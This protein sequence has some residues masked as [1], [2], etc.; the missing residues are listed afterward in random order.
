MSKRLLVSL[1]LLI[2]VSGLALG[3]ASGGSGGA[4]GACTGGGSNCHAGPGG[5]GGPGGTVTVAPTTSAE[6]HP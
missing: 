3:C 2:S 4:G 5:N 6:L 1:V